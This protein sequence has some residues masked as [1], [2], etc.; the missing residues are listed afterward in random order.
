MTKE[1]RAGD[2]APM[3]RKRPEAVSPLLTGRVAP[4][5]ERRA[6]DGGR[7]FPS[8]DTQSRSRPSGLSRRGFARSLLGAAG[9]L[10]L[11]PRGLRA[12][13]RPRE[14]AFVHTH[15]GEELSIVYC[16]ELGYRAEALARL[17]ALLR[18]FRSEEVH[19]IDP[20]LFDLLHEVHAATGS[21]APFQVIS[22]YRSPATNQR[23][24]RRSEGVALGSLHLVGRAI[25]VRLA[26]VPTAR[27]R[28]AGLALARGGVGYYADS[29]F[30]HLDT[31]RVRRW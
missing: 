18:D 7:R 3:R 14:L 16:D 22:G 4:V 11:A 9:L 31:G 17:D 28:D 30:V 15:T 26:D 29:D 2:L 21:R 25:D 24:H 1:S 6:R 8:L 27:L 13:V 5:H 23:L 12:M 10:L 19:P 20:A